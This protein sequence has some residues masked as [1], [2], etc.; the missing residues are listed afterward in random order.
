MTLRPIESL[1]VSLIALMKQTFR[2]VGSSQETQNAKNNR[3]LLVQS[4][5][6]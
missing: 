3:F 5:C 1:C 4:A 2:Q 6:L